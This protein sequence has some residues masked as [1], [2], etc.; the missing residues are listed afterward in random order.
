MPVVQ[1]KLAKKWL[2]R[3]VFTV[4]IIEILYVT[5]ELFWPMID[6]HGIIEEGGYRDLLIGDEKNSVVIKLL[7]PLNGNNLKI[8]GYEGPDHK[9]VYIFDR[10]PE[11]HI[12]D[13]DKW[14]LSFPGIHNEVVHLVFK[15][16][17]LVRIEYSRDILAP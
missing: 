10:N 14:Y 16:G 15:N 2:C 6:D 13:S 1:T 17:K 9:T 8:I 12:L 5:H 7:S 11:I 4:G 3:F